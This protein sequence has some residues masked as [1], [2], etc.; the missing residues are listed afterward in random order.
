MPVYNAGEHKVDHPPLFACRD[1]KNL[2]R[3]TEQF[4]ND[5]LAAAEDLVPGNLAEYAAPMLGGNE[6]AMRLP[7]Y[8]IPPRVIV[9]NPDFLRGPDALPFMLVFINKRFIGIPAKYLTRE[10]FEGCPDCIV[11]GGAGGSAASDD[12]GFA[13]VAPGFRSNTPASGTRLPPRPAPSKAPPPRPGSGMTQR[14]AQKPQTNIIRKPPIP[15][16]DDVPGQRPRPGR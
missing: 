13:D 4:V 15:G 9:Y 14:P 7:E 5:I 16:V 12:V 8:L 2:L 3:L 10:R 11:Q 1:H 6:S